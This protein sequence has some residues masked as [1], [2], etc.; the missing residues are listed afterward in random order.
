MSRGLANWQRFS[1]R[2]L[3]ATI[4]AGLVG[5]YLFV[6][7]LAGLSLY[8]SR[9]QY[10]LRAQTLT[11]NMALA[12]DQSLSNSISK[13]DLALRAVADELEHELAAGHLDKRSVDAMLEKYQLRLPEVEAFRIANAE[14][15]VVAGKGL[16]PAARAS[17]ADREYFT[18]LRDHPDGGLQVSKPRVGRVAKKYIIGFAR[19]YNFPDGRF[20]GVISAPVA[21]DYFSVLLSQFNVGAKGVVA[22]RD[23]DL[24]L[25]TRYP[26]IPKGPASTVGNTTVSKE[27]RDAVANGLAAAT[28]HTP[29]GAD[30]I[31]RTN[32]FRRISQAPMIV[33]A[34]VASE[35]YLASWTTE[36][37]KTLAVVAGFIAVTLL[38]A[39]FVLHL[40]KRI[41]AESQRNELYLHH[42]SDGIHILDDQG[43]V[44]QASDR[45]CAM[46]GYE[47]KEIIGMSV[48]RWDTRWPAETL[49]SEILP[50][51]LR[52]ETASTFETR[53]TTKAG[54]ILDVEVSVVG[55]TMDRRRY[56]FA[57][58][59][60]IG[61]RRRQQQVLQ[62]SELRLRESEARYRLLLQHS[63][64]GIL[65]Y[66]P[67]LVITYA[68][69]RFEDIVKVPRGHAL[70]LDCK[71]LHDQSVV[72]ALT[73]AIQG[74]HGRYE[75]PYTTTFGNVGLWIS[76]ACAP[77][78]D[79]AG[80]ILGG[81]AIIEDI[82]ERKQ[83]E[84]VE[85]R[86][87]ES[88]AD[89]NDIAAL[90]HLPLADQLHQALAIGAKHFGLEFGI[91]NRRQD[92]GE[93]IL[94]QVS[95]PDAP[96]DETL[97]AIAGACCP[98]PMT[99]RKVVA[100]DAMGRSPHA[101]HPCHRQCGM[102]AY[103]GAPVFV[104]AE[105]YGTVNFSSPHPYP[106]PF[107]AGDREFAGL[108]ARWVGSTI[109]REQ[110]RQKLVE[111]EAR[112]QAIIESEPECVKTV[113]ADGELLQ[114]NRAGLDMLEARNVAD[115]NAAGLYSFIAPE[116]RLAFMDSVRR[117]FEGESG[118][119]QFMVDGKLGTRRWLDTHSTPLRDGDGKI[120]ALL[121]V[122]RDITKQKQS[123]SQLRLAASVFS[124]AHEGLMIFDAQRT[125]VD[126]NPM[127][128]AITGYGRDEV[129]GLPLRFPG[130][131]AQSGVSRALWQSVDTQGYWK[132]EVSNRRKD[133]AAYTELLSISEVRDENGYLTNYIGAF[134][135]ISA[136]KEQQAQ[137]EHLAHY[138]ALTHLPNRTLLSD[139][140]TQALAQAR[141]AG[142]LVA[143]GYLDLDGFKAI[144]DELGHDAGDTLLIEVAH[145]LREALRSGDTVARLGGDEFV[146]LLVG[147]GSIE[148][149]ELAATRVLR[150]LAAPFR[151][152]EQERRISGSLGITLFPKDDAD[153][154]TLLRHADQAMYLAKQSGKNR[155][156]FAPRVQ[157][158]R[159]AKRRDAI[160]HIRQ[161]L[162][163]S[164]FRLYYQPIVDMRH[165]EVV[166]FEGLLR[167]QHPE[168]GLLLP[169]EFL[170]LTEDSDLDFTLG[171]WVLAEGLRQLAVWRQAGMT[172]SLSLNV[173]AGHLL[174]PGFVEDLNA[175]KGIHPWLQPHDLCLDVLE[176][177]VARDIAAATAVFDHCHEIGIDIALDDFGSGY[178]SLASFRRLPVDTLKIDQLFVQSV[179]AG[180]EELSIVESVISFT[181]AFHRRLIAEGV[182]SIEIGMLMLNMGCHIGQG[183]G[184]A[185]PMPAA[186]VAAW[187]ENFKRDNTWAF[188]STHLSREDL[189]L[190][191]AELEHRAWAR[192]L[193]AWLNAEPGAAQPPALSD[194]ECQFGKWYGGAGQKLTRFPSF[195]TL[196]GTH[197][198]IHRLG[199]ELTG[200]VNAGQQAQA[201]ERIAELDTLSTQLIE[202]IGTLQ[203]E[204][205]LENV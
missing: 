59:R 41:L 50:T 73:L 194:Q 28:Y 51:L 67:D 203:A 26:L 110:A 205:V 116:H 106:R 137:L 134:S 185:R 121:A 153:P 132:G 46:L 145:R 138:D 47:R 60:D 107:D 157:D 71:A 111:S 52:Q 133:G 39:G 120:I 105:A 204:I 72:P 56:L 79:T 30:G 119:L 55:I 180:S 199:D 160:D 81:I 129:I 200:L 90:S 102:E 68:N 117:V 149:C 197:Q 37:Y 22:L 170:S 69:E 190:Y 53:H 76:M 63:P 142:S 109:E 189:P 5:A 16:D 169:Q 15:L 128:T 181:Q 99:E 9:Q 196:D 77:L 101:D 1:P 3:Q 155:Y 10:E 173:S 202:Q 29:A 38:A 165:G 44:V 177:A 113:A 2:K 13:I 146:L 123:E 135:D 93:Q 82:T 118:V 186:D 193:K 92:D 182:E 114:M 188:P 17:W 127:F 35:E 163:A 20:A 74:Q 27:L 195:Q 162:A 42:A 97:P 131:D 61:E 96:A 139:R 34:G 108:L 80:A 11:Q 168:R 98:I 103:I 112:L 191:M 48:A 86:Q 154:D 100:I 126:V 125:I 198:A 78:V 201:R 23:S 75:G 88:L 152:K 136:L 130:S 171:R 12:V 175:L 66:G 159:E 143:V 178:S 54:E 148:E 84:E 62:D 7:A 124:H 36:V 150:S 141:R 95:P 151:L 4:V 57:A 14:G 87:R 19:R 85:R 122:T 184:I 6:L 31:E 25:I 115:V 147:I 179:L 192:H 104:G 21:V 94:A 164:E 40:L 144:N 70:G 49:L 91:I 58:S 167:W 161:G 172:Q 43:N 140:M 89:L 174:S 166:G 18:F 64:I 32:S 183:H 45:F 187:L 156:H 33:V 24:G 176:D 83:I 158:I 8:Q 65:H